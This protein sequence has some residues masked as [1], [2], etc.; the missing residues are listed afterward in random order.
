[1]SC[2]A[3]ARLAW[4]LWALATALVPVALVF[5][6]LSRSAS[7]P[8]GRE[9]LLP[10]IVPLALIGL[11]YATVGA[12]VGSRRPRNPLGWIFC[13][14]G[15][16][17]ALVAA[18]YGYADYGIYANGD[19][20]APRYA[21]WLTSWLFIFP[22]FI[23]PCLVL[24]LFPD[25]RPPSPRWRPFGWLFAVFGL[26]AVAWSALEP[27]TLDTYPT[28]ANPLALHG[29]AGELATQMNTFGEAAG[30]PALFLF[31]LASIVVRYRRA[32]GLERLQIKWVA[33]AAAVMVVCFAASFLVGE[34]LPGFASDTLF[35]LGI[36]SF[37]GI[38][39]AAGI[40]ILRHR[41]YDIDRIVNRTV[42]Y[43]V[44]TAG[45]AGLYF[46]VVLALQAAFDSLTQGNELA[47][48]GS[49]LAVAAL[50]RPARRRVQA[51]VDRRFYR[52]RYD[53]QQTLAA[54]SSRLRDEI[55]LDALSVELT[56]VVRETMQ[57]AHV[58]LWLRE[59][60]R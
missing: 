46:A 56:G 17:L 32:D 14:I 52:R 57:P 24:F 20:P 36:A 13:A 9:Q 22:V 43:G 44:L 41:L 33:Y 8:E 7:L 5:G 11:V 39:V 29:W 28:V 31:S 38:A 6:I 27:T 10:F 54:F 58:S 19:V 30:A 35:V 55:D 48:A 51:L 37:G 26:A 60:D 12:V 21:A 42:V 53:A 16:G 50:F 3:A 1:V 4:G 40:A 59:A 45:L 47:I 25:G 15:L 49:T 18:A 34:S 23:A 2:T